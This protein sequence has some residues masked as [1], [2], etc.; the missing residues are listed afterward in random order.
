MFSS[1]FDKIDKINMPPLTKIKKIYLTCTPNHKSLFLLSFAAKKG[2]GVFSKKA[3]LEN[4][5]PFLSTVN[6]CQ[7]IH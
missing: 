4:N 2:R 3:Q 1:I 7:N 6:A 5:A